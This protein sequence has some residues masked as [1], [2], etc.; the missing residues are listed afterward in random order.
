MCNCPKIQFY[1]I[2]FKLWGMQVVPTHKNCG[3]ALSEA[4]ASKF[5]KELMKLW[6]ME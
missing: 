4:Q 5:N 2:E 1:E 3:D 6:N